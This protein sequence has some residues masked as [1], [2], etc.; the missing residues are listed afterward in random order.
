V[1]ETFA[2]AYASFH[3]FEPGTS[4]CRSSGLPTAA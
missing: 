2:K 3:Q 1:Q 4:R